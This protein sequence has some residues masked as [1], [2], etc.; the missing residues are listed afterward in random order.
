[1]CRDGCT[2]GATGRVG[3]DGQRGQGQEAWLHSDGCVGERETPRDAEEDVSEQMR[4][5]R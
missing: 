1:M 5:S 3:V 4:A 2:G